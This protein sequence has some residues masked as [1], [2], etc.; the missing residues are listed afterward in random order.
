MAALRASFNNPD[1]AVQYLLSV[2]HALPCTDFV[3][4][5]PQ[6]QDAAPQ[7]HQQQQQQQQIQDFGMREDDEGP[8]EGDD[9]DAAQ[10]GTDR[11]F[12]VTCDS[13]EISLPRFA[14]CYSRTLR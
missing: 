12:A 4:G 2:R 3:Q 10:V 14:S 11:C 5:I 7:Q 1:R 6:Q 13:W 8:E 9:M